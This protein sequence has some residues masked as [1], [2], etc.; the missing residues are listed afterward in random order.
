[1]TELDKRQ[2]R[3][4]FTGHRPEKLHCSEIEVKKM[5]AKEIATALKQGKRTFITGMARGS[6][7]YAAELVL[8]YRAQYSDIHLICAL[9]HPDFEKYWSPE[10][11]QRYRKILKAA[12]YVKLIRPEFSMSSYQ[13]RNEW[14]V[15]HSSL[16]IAVYNGKAGGTRNTIEYANKCHV[17]VH[18]LYGHEQLSCR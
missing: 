3:C 11:Q 12:D 8:E 1:M 13:I 6:D 9:P 17:E 15:D 4:C 2:N 10:W 5:L 7:I 16:L 18:M 14:M